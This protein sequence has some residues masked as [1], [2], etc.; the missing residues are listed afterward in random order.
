[1]A[2]Y[3][4]QKEIKLWIPMTTAI[5]QSIMPPISVSYPPV[6][7]TTSMKYE[8]DRADLIAKTGCK[9]TETPEAS[10]MEYIHGDNGGAILIHQNLL[11]DR[12]DEQ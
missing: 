5:F 6:Y 10:I 3:P 4:A 7:I 8:K 12:N 1:M 2:R 9:H 11:P